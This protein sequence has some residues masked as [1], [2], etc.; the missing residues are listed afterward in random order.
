MPEAAEVD[1]GRPARVVVPG[2]HR[3]VGMCSVNHFVLRVE[4]MH[5]VARLRR[6]PGHETDVHTFREKRRLVAGTREE[7]AHDRADGAEPLRDFREHRL[8]RRTVR[9]PELVGVA[10]DHPVRAELRRGK[11]CHSR[12]P[13]DLAH[14]VPR[15]AD[16]VEMACA[17][18]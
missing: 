9:A 3:H 12:H 16:Q 18:V 17:F 6:F 8:Q 2:A 1:R 11:S 15:L 13:F 5:E 7:V 10:V 4:R 14:V